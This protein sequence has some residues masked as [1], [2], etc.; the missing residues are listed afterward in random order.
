MHQAYLIYQEIFLTV[1]FKERLWPPQES[2]LYTIYL[3]PDVQYFFLVG[4]LSQGPFLLIVL[5]R[6]NKKA[7]IET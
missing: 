3:L 6:K 7:G 1:L 2:N 5:L 4:L